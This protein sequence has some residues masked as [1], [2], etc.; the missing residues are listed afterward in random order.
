M[1]VTPCCKN[2]NYGLYRFYLSICHIKECQLLIITQLSTEWAMFSTWTNNATDIR[3]RYSGCCDAF[4]MLP[5]PADLSLLLHSPAHGRGSLRMCFSSQFTPS[6][7][8]SPPKKE[9]CTK[10]QT[11]KQKTTTHERL[12]TSTR[13][14]TSVQDPVRQLTD[15]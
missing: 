8:M 2:E 13:P 15:F 10:K 5:K 4:A 12:H 9:I 6:F 7:R 3:G 11:N 1:T 14:D